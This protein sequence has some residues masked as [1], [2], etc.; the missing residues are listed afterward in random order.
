MENILQVTGIPPKVGQ[1]YDARKTVS[2]TLSVLKKSGAVFR[3]RSSN[4]SVQKVLS[5]F[6]SHLRQSGVTLETL[7][8][9]N[10]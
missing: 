4:V 10:I 1:N 6:Y 3:P 8:L 5:L 9:E 2:A 7:G